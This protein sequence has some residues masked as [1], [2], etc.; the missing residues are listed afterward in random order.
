MDAALAVRSC[1]MMRRAHP[2]DR[3]E[4]GARDGAGTAR[5]RR[6]TCRLRRES[7][8]DDGDEQRITGLCPNDRAA[9]RCLRDRPG[10]P[11]N[12]LDI[13][14]LE[15]AFAHFEQR[16]VARACPS[17]G[18]KRMQG[19]SFD[20]H[21]EVS[22]QFSPLMSCTTQLPVQERS[23]GMTSPTPLPDRVGANA[24]TCSGPAWRR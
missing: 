22:C 9:R 24:S 20:R 8:Q 11:G 5:S 12:V 16:I 18:S 17:V 15:V 4:Q 21:P 2:I 3:L 7:M 1:E 19:P 14:D 10:C 23:V 6:A 13:P